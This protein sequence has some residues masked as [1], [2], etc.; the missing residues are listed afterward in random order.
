MRPHPAAFM[1]R[2]HE[3]AAIAGAR[4]LLL[5]DTYVSGARSQSAAA[6]LQLAGARPVIAPLGRVL[7]PDRV[8][9]HAEF[10]R[11]HTA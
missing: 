9:L 11:R 8:A 3:R 7:R 1:V 10:L 5:D 6:A 4:V 2:A